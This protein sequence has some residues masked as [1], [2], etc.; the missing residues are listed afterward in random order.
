[1]WVQTSR[2]LS[3]ISSKKWNLAWFV[4]YTE[5]FNRIHQPL[6]VDELKRRYQAWSLAIE[7]VRLTKRLKQTHT[8]YDPSKT[9][10]I[11][12]RKEIKRVLADYGRLPPRHILQEDWIVIKGHLWPPD[13]IVPS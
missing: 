9:E 4:D 7:R 10:Q 1:M 13:F 12:V 11:S 5:A 2:V 3:E 8:S 6:L